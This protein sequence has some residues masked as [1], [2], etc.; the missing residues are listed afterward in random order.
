VDGRL[1]E[2]ELHHP[3]ELALVVGDAAAGAAHRE[4]WPQD[5]R[6]ADLADRLAGLR[7]GGHQLRAR[8]RQADPRHRL[9]EQLAILGHLDRRRRRA[10]QLDPVLLEQ[11]GLPRRHR[12]VEPGLAAERGQDRVDLLPREDLVE[13][14]DGE[15]LDVGRVGE[16]RVGHD[17]RRVRV[18]QDDAQ[19]L[20]AERLAGLGARVVELARLA[21]HDR[22]GADDQDGLEIVTLRH[23]AG[24]STDTDSFDG[25]RARGISA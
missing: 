11:A 16:L 24:S 3:V 9:L 12:E 13:H 23:G 20:L 21:D 10:E 4:R 2:P 1:I 17:R 25:P 14:L 22:A 19:A 15:R 18:D 8:T 7:D 6:E 5:R